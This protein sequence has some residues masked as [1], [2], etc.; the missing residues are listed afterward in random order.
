MA[1]NSLETFQELLGYRFRN[2]HFLVEALTHS[3]FAQESADRVRDNEQLEFLGDAVLN[4]LVS[5][6]LVGAFPQ[7]PEGQLTRA[8]SRLVAAP[9]LGRVATKLGLG[10][11]LRLGRGE[12][13]TGGRS[14]ANL[15]V[16]AL[17][18]VVA[19]LYCD[20][21][22]EAARAFVQRFILPEDLESS[23]DELF[24]VD[25]KSA[26]QEIL[27]AERQMPVEYR[28]IEES[29]P[30]HQ[31][32]FTVEVIVGENVVAR[33]RGGSKKVAEQQAARVALEL[34]GRKANADA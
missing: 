12:E 8:R 7:T 31:K 21:G 14:K 9:H 28:I 5:V 34:L 3:S 33:G 27:Q 26:L 2:I 25:Y 11:Y 4:F 13:K 6:V 29:G 20:G 32:I 10:G 17:E 24:W 15:L 1:E 19:A 30:Q 16:N 22:L 18:A 23:A